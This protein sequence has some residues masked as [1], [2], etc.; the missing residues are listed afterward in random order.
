MGTRVSRWL[1]AG[2]RALRRGRFDAAIAAF[3]KAVE[4]A[5]ND[6]RAHIRLAFALAR[7][8]DCETARLA[9]R[10]MFNRFPDDPVVHLCA[11]C[12][13][14]E[15]DDPIGAE[16][17]LQSA[18]GSQPENA[19]VR[20]YLALCALMKGD[21]AGASARIE[22]AGLAANADFLALF[23]YEVEQRIMPTAPMTDKDAPLASQ[24]YGEAIARLAA[25]A[26]DGPR[27]S[28]FA[29]MRR[30]Q[31]WRKL[32][33]L[34][35]RAYDNGNFARALAAFE[36]AHRCG[37]EDLIVWLGAG[38]SSLRLERP[39]SA[40]QWLAE[41]FARQ[42]EDAIIASHYADALYRAGRIAEALA[43]FEK[44]EPAGPDDFHAHYGC[45]A[46]L[47]ALGRKREALEQFR[48]AFER[49]RLDTLEE[50]LLPSWQ[51]LLKEVGGERQGAG[52]QN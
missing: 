42:P 29:K 17:L 34:G 8:G 1:R 52:G 44:I 39:N 24:S 36:A 33:S 9:I 51:G 16:P 49:Y 13:L 21:L 30:R 14:L 45:G 12:C 5:P 7:Q 4:A 47:A 20:Q 15:C 40:A 26:T 37:S 27:L 28:F 10:T 22:Q 31:V 43:V 6:R 41:G 23:S 3:G 32:A 38:L 50:C 46:C 19:L 2:H 11:G 25:Q 18:A 48:I 35:E